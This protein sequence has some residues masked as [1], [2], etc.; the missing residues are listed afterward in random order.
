MI[1]EKKL[2]EYLSML[3]GLLDFDEGVLDAN[4]L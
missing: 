4:E 1:G 3:A 2:S